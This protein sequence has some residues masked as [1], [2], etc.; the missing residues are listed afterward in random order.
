MMSGISRESRPCL[1]HQPQLRLDCSPP[2]SPFSHSTT[3]IFFFAR[4]KAALVPMMPPPMTTTAARGGILVSDA[5][6]ST[7]GPMIFALAYP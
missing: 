7:F 2:I 6:G 3:G 1:R 5:T 4:N